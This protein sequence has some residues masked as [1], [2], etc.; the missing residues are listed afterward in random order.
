MWKG[1]LQQKCMN[2]DQGYFYD[3]YDISTLCT[4]NTDCLSLNSV[5]QTFI[6]EKSTVN[7]DSGVAGFLRFQ[8]R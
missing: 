5:G 6:C 1:L 4:D 8:F 3:V 7:P 2:V